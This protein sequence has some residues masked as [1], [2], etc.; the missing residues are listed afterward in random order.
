MELQYQYKRNQVTVTLSNSAG[1]KIEV[2]GDM[3]N[4]KNLLSSQK[5]GPRFL[6]PQSAGLTYPDSDESED[7]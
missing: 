5:L 2:K 1:V 7:D 4:V 3:Q 6:N